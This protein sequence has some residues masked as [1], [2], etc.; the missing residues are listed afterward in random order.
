MSSHSRLTEGHSARSFLFP[1]RMACACAAVAV[2]AAPLYAYDAPSVLR[3]EQ[4]WRLI[5]NEPNDDVQSPQLHTTMLLGLDGD[6]EPYVVQV[7][8]NYREHP[9]FEAGGVQ[10]QLWHGEERVASQHVSLA[11][12]S[13]PLE[14]ITWTQIVEIDGSVVSFRISDGHSTTWGSFGRGMQLVADTSLTNLNGY[15]TRSSMDGS[16]ITYGANR[17]DSLTITGVRWYG[18]EGL[19]LDDALPHVVYRLEGN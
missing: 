5:L 2:T 3:V 7:C 14:T 17:V 11:P 18:Q 4:D 12:L 10:V 16:M 15:K 8:W 9:A 1:V 19:L 13:A 6:S